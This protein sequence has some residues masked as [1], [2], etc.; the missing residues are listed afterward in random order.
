M[1]DFNQ[2]GNR[3]WKFTWKTKAHKVV[4]A[5]LGSRFGQQDLYFPNPH[6]HWN[7]NDIFFP[8]W[9][10]WGQ[11]GS[12]LRDHIYKPQNVHGLSCDVLFHFWRHHSHQ[13][14][15]KKEIIAQESNTR[16][17]VT[18]FSIYALPLNDKMLQLWFDY[19]LI[20][21]MKQ[22]ILLFEL[23][24]WLY[25]RGGRIAFERGK[26]MPNYIFRERSCWH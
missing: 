22:D 4:H 6:T 23:M 16:K 20:V 12:S 21:Y 9:I 2:N 8:I 3:I 5:S 1:F 26:V 15:G 19:W 14:K 10:L 25:R 24:I 7:L 18:K 11:C 17:I 13:K